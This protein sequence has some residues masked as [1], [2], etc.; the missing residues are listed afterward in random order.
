MDFLVRSEAVEL[1]SFIDAAWASFRE[2]TPCTRGVPEAVRR[3]K[4]MR[5]AFYT[6]TSEFLVKK[7]FE[8]KMFAHRLVNG[9]FA[10]L[11]AQPSGHS[12]EDDNADGAAEQ[13]MRERV[14]G[15]SLQVLSTFDQALW[16]R[17]EVIARQ[18]RFRACSD[19]ER[20]QLFVEEEYHS[21]LHDTPEL[22][23]SVFKPKYGIDN[24]SCEEQV[25]LKRAGIVAVATVEHERKALQRIAD[26]WTTELR[27]MAES[28]RRRLPETAL[29]S[30]SKR[31]FFKF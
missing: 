9:V 31:C 28:M 29:Q 6:L 24:E 27:S 13:T 10:P 26:L 30:T 25:L 22:D 16:A 12:V 19:L 4:W 23:A 20:F 3:A 15:I 18:S 17:W 2:S 1:Q 8:S 21:I 5:D 14:Q 11:L 7:S